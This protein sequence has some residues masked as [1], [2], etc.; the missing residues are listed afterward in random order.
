MKQY[1]LG[2]VFNFTDKIKII[3]FPHKDLNLTHWT[4]SGKAT[5]MCFCGVNC[6]GNRPGEEFDFGKVEV[7]S[8]T[9]NTGKPRAPPEIRIILLLTAVTTNRK[10]CAR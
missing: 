3:E 1:Y 5:C 4:N 6:C 9:Y 2:C 7:T 8:D 10:I